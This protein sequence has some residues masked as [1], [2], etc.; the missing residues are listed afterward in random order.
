MT[1][2]HLAENGVRNKGAI[3][4]AKKVVAKKVS[5]LGMP[6][7]KICEEA[8][9]SHTTLNSILRGDSVTYANAEKLAKYFLSSRMHKISPLH[10][11]HTLQRVL[12]LSSKFFI[13]TGIHHPPLSQ[14]ST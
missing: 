14:H 9:I 7:C 6:K 5:A 12:K 4:T 8:G 11:F 1:P 13:T 10:G 2:K 3:A